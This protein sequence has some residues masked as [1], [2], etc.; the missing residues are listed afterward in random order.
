MTPSGRAHGFGEAE[1]M[2]Y[3]W[4][5]LP[6]SLIK[7]VIGVCDALLSELR[8][9]HCHP[10]LMN[11]MT[12]REAFRRVGADERDAV[13]DR[14]GVAK[15]VPDEAAAGLTWFGLRDRRQGIVR[16]VGYTAR[17][18]RPAECDAGGGAFGR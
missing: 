5:I 12:V 8:S 7:A 2:G 11:G 4:A 14:F 15:P 3:R 10:V 13:S 1:R 18:Y 9:N 17:H 16:V 6:G